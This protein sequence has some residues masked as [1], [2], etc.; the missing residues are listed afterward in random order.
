VRKGAD[1]VKL[2]VKGIAEKYGVTKTAV[3]AWINA[4]LPVENQK[5]VG[6][7]TRKIIDIKDVEAFHKNKEDQSGVR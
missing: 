1:S 3:Y 4:G 2:T 5:V 6:V 7:K